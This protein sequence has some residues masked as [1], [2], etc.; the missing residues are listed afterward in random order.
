MSWL[1]WF[2]WGSCLPL[3]L[4]GRWCGRRHQEGTFAFIVLMWLLVVLAFMALPY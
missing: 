1:N 4:I 3:F 2:V